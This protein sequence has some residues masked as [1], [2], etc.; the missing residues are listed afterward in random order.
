LYPSH[1]DPN[2]EWVL[3]SSHDEASGAFVGMLF[4]Q[5]VDY[6]EVLPYAEE[7][8]EPLLFSKFDGS[9]SRRFAWGLIPAYEV[10]GDK[11]YLTKLINVSETLISFFNMRKGIYQTMDLFHGELFIFYLEKQ[12]IVNM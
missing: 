9:A 10:T 2:G 1:L 6:P 7:Y 5:S 8:A 11:K 3:V 12:E 4:E